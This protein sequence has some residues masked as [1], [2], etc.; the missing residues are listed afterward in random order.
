MAA[1]VRPA[2][3]VALTGEMRNELNFQS[4]KKNAGERTLGQL[5]SRLLGTENKQFGVGSTVGIF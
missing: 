3:N 1:W 5:R 4:L 2:V